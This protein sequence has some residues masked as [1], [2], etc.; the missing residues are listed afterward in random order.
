MVHSVLWFTVTGFRVGNEAE[1][2]VFLEFSCFLYDPVNADNLISGSS[3][4]SKPCLFIWKFLVHILLKP[5]LKDFE[6]NFAGMWN[7]HNYNVFEHSLALPFFSTQYMWT[8]SVEYSRTPNYKW[9]LERKTNVCHQ[10]Q[11]CNQS[12]VYELLLSTRLWWLKMAKLWSLSLT[13]RLRR[14]RWM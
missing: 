8:E 11:L 12:T 9:M 4:S 13:T 2:D 3:V 1:V 10:S 14:Q 7:E 6:Y 5:S